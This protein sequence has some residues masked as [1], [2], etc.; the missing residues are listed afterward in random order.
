MA[1]KYWNGSEWVV[2]AQKVWDGTQWADVGGGAL[3]VTAGNN[4]LLTFG[5]TKGETSFGYFPSSW[6]TED[7]LTVKPGVD[8]S[9]RIRM[10]LY[11]DDGTYRILKN[12]A[13]VA[14]TYPSPGEFVWLKDISLSPDDV[15]VFQST[16]KYDAIMIGI[17]EP[18]STIDCAFKII[19]PTE[20][21]F[22]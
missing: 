6:S 11:D 20:T 7:M 9:I 2:P 21:L 10:D 8:G 15:L 17:S 4:W 3:E 19:N 12:G 5:T 18:I 22:N 16:D 1:T 13:E 14:R